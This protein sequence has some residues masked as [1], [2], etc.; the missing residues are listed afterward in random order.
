MIIWCSYCQIFIGETEPYH[1]FSLSHGICEQCEKS[2]ATAH[3]KT[4][5]LARELGEIHKTIR[6]AARRNDLEAVELAI[7]H[8][9]AAGIRSADILMGVLSPLLYKIGLAWQRG[10][11]TIK[12]EHHFTEFAE[13]IYKLIAAKTQSALP[14]TN[15]SERPI[16]LMN[17]TTNAH[18]LGVRFVSLW[19]ESLGLRSKIVEMPK[20]YHDLERNIHEYAPKFLLISLS[21]AD[22]RDEVV[23]LV[24]GVHRLPKALQPKII[25]GGYAVKT[26]S[27]EEI[28]GTFSIK[29]VGRLRKFIENEL[30]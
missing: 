5:N 3:E 27:I 24:Q 6:S 22:Q 21:I 7:E 18:N 16:L 28:P 15:T 9:N 8:A 10:N 30:S 26:D 25:I 20:N 19:L 29:D 12:E 23:S 1:N 4:I 11:I 13:K 2:I 14:P 17:T